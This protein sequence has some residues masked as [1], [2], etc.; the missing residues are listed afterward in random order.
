VSRV[1]EAPI[2]PLRDDANATSEFR[3][4]GTASSRS[5]P[6]VTEVP[7]PPL[8]TASTAAFV[9]SPRRDRPTDIRAVE[10]AVGHT[11]RAPITLSHAAAGGA[12]NRRLTV[13]HAA[14]DDRE[15]QAS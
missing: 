3:A 7:V 5:Q 8:P 2:F 15:L 4:P 11:E 13:A 1:T 9:D 6:R 12:P 14:V 10:L